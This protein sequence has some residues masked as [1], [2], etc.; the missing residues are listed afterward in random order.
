MTTSSVTA[1]P[2]VENDFFSSVSTAFEGVG[3]GLAFTGRSILPRFFAKEFLD[4]SGDQL[5]NPTFIPAFADPT[6][7][8]GQTTT[9]QPNIRPA[10]LD[11]QFGGVQIPATT[12]LVV[13][14]GILAAILLLGFLRR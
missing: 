4:Q 7:D 12:V 14:G 11:F 10:L 5:A 8:K 1:S 13:G 9:A 6:L 3:E 2:A